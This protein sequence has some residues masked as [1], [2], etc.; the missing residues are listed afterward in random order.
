M[1]SCI[2]DRSDRSK[3]GRLDL[4]QLYG[5]IKYSINLKCLIIIRRSGLSNCMTPCNP[6]DAVIIIFLIYITQIHSA[7]T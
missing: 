1:R 2:H 5:L 6:V 4:K 7:L 3:I